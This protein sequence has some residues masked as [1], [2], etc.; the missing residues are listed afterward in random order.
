MTTEH[1]QSRPLT[2]ERMRLDIAAILGESPDQLEND[3]NLLDWGL[4]SMR[5]FNLSVEWNKTGLELRFAD[6][7]ETPT[8][9]GWWQQVQRQQSGV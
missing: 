8:L 6:L 3:D 7:A 1:S 5:I 4:D 2:L 9:D